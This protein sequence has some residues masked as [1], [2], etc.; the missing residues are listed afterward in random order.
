MIKPPVELAIAPLSPWQITLCKGG[1]GGGRRV[2]N[3]ES[4]HGVVAPLVRLDSKGRR[5]H[6]IE[7]TGREKKNYKYSLRLNCS[8]FLF[9]LLFYF[10]KKKKLQ[11]IHTICHLDF[12]HALD[13]F[14]PC[15][16]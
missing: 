9:P 2:E 5:D 4:E 10:K 14:S 1:G 8:L 11:N 6:Q 15:K 3:R 7:K 13:W 12:S 16:A